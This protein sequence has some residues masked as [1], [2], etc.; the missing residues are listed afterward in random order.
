M[1]RIMNRTLST[2]NMP[3]F[4]T[5]WVTGGISDTGILLHSKSVEDLMNGEFSVNCVSG[6][7]PGEKWSAYYNS[8]PP[9][10]ISYF[11]KGNWPGFEGSIQGYINQK[12]DFEKTKYIV[13][14]DSF[15]RT[16]YTV[17]FP[18]KY[19]G[20]R[21]GVTVHN[22]LGG[23]SSY[24]PHKFELDAMANPIKPFFYETFAYLTIPFYGWGIQIAANNKTAWFVKN[25]DISKIPLGSHPVVASPETKLAYI[26]VYAGGEEKFSG[27]ERI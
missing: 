16:V 19:L 21:M 25:R 2:E 18:N 1:V 20:L 12:N 13:G 14:K 22:I 23:W 17:N 4:T 15:E 10:D 8:V 27:G 5:W 24:P 7:D 3:P 26:W 6:N 9:K 11:V